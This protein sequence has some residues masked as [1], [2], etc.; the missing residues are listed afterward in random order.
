MGGKACKTGVEGDDCA[1]R[2]RSRHG[3]HYLRHTG[4][5]GDSAGEGSVVRPNFSA[6]RH[7]LAEGETWILEIFTT[8][9]LTNT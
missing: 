8:F 6:I 1:T 4:L 7:Y 5:G 2:P 9:A 3:N